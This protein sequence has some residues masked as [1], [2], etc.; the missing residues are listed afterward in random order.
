MRI[1]DQSSCFC[2]NPSQT[3]LHLILKCDR[4]AAQRYRFE[5]ESIQKIYHI[6]INNHLEIRI[7]LG[8][9]R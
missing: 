4:F 3:S 6:N 7:F 8:N 2:G 5:I 1:N 9:N